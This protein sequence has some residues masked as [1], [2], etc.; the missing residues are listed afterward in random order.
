[1][2][3]DVPRSFAAVTSTDCISLTGVR[4]VR[5]LRRVKDNETVN[6]P[7]KGWEAELLNHKAAPEAIFTLTFEEA[8]EVPETGVKVKSS[9]VRLRVVVAP[10]MEKTI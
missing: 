7:P 6:W 1:M 3:F 9:C 10:V 2:E 4:F 5:S 8:R